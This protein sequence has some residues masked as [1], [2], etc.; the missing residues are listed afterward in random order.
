[1]KKRKFLV[2]SNRLPVSVTKKDGVLQFSPSSG[3][4][5]TA[6]ARVHSEGDDRLWIGWPGIASDELNSSEKSKI[7]RELNKLGCHPIFLTKKQIEKYY[8]GYS[9]DT[10]WPLFHYFQTYVQHDVDYFEGYKQVNEIFKKAVL[11]F[12]DKNTSIWIHDYH[13]ML[14]PKLIR[15]TLPDATIGFFLHIPFPSYEIFR[16]LPNRKEILEGL[17][18]AN[19]V[20]FHVYDYARHFLS[21]VLRILAIEN[22]HGTIVIGQRAVKADAFP[23]GIDYEKF[24]N[25][26]KMPKTQKEINNLEK[27]Y[28]GVKTILSMDRLDYSKGIARRLA[29][30]EEFLKENPA[31]RKKVV[32]VVVAVPSRMQVA[33]YRKL[34][35]TIEEQISRI[36][37]KYGTSK[38]TPVSYQFKNL[39]FEQVS[40]LFWVADIALL[41]PLRD[42]MNLVAKEYIATKQDRPGVLILSEMAGAVDE[43]PEAIRINPNDN[44][45]II[46]AIKSGLELSE[47]TQKTNIKL[48]QQ[49]LSKYT[50]HR[51]AEDFIEQLEETRHWQK[52]RGDKL[53][54]S[55]SKDKILKSFK[56][57]KSRLILLDYDGT[58][59]SFVSSHHPGK[60]APSK[61][62]VSL[63]T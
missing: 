35:L 63:L 3:G 25:S 36:N 56:N 5:A 48:M 47:I 11:K 40:A 8:D 31:Q 58:L 21:S 22:S 62:L 49:R 12:T 60:A 54:S 14:L 10:I 41:T 46:K 44:R 4:L 20:G 55:E 50:V 53:L 30:F 27:K 38:W 19:L 61:Q 18:G 9:N 29:A 34:R 42:G 16:L 23:I 24:A 1:M 28:A 15:D 13:L 52:H 6:L 43:M 26:H 33:T 57:S 59:R 45:E 37:K 39:P 17:L 7:V 51:W 2:V 32:L